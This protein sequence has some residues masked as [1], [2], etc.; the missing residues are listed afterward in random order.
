MSPS[1]TMPFTSTDAPDVSNDGSAI[2]V[3]NVQSIYEER[4]GRQSFGYNN[5]SG[6]PK[7]FSHH[8]HLVPDEGQLVEAE[9]EEEEEEEDNRDQDYN[10]GRECVD[11]FVESLGAVLAETA[12]SR[13]RQT[14][15][16]CRRL[17]IENDDLRRALSDLE[18]RLETMERDV[19][20][21]LDVRS[22]RGVASGQEQDE[23]EEG[24]LLVRL[25]RNQLELVTQQTDKRV[26]EMHRRIVLLEDELS[27]SELGRIDDALTADRE[28][29]DLASSYEEKLTNAC[30]LMAELQLDLDVTRESKADVL[31]YGHKRGGGGGRTR[32]RGL[33]RGRSAVRNGKLNRR[34]R[35]H[36]HH[37]Q[38]QM[39]GK[40]ELDVGPS[41]ARMIEEGV[42]KV[43]YYEG[44]AGDGDAIVVDSDGNADEYV[45]EFL[46]D[47]ADIVDDDDN[48][49]N[50]NN[51]NNAEEEEE[52]EEKT[53]EK[54]TIHELRDRLAA[55]D[56]TDQRPR[57]ELTKQARIVP[58]SQQQQQQRVAAD[59]EAQ[60]R[61]GLNVAHPGGTNASKSPLHNNYHEL[62]HTS[63]RTM[64][65][66]KA[67]DRQMD[68]LSPRA[69]TAT[70]TFG[71]YCDM[72]P[73][74]KAE[75]KRL[76]RAAR[77][78]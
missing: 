48:D 52:E 71:G 43:T 55:T 58:Q 44:G 68:D 9:A 28:M 47:S 70:P 42:A 73:Q 26:R 35:Q 37:Q 1:L 46:K 23:D 57:A 16:E 24:G 31:S 27:L 50:N 20:S 66:L 74:A 72:S 25:L 39:S 8:H 3:D 62:P 32:R 7:A 22:K 2:D 75:P 67:L 65:D 61:S 34:V 10:G 76:G 33:G 63:H 6:E 17:R 36:R 53:E 21:A 29:R 59:S 13:S 77:T 5:D 78:A 11:R 60:A 69:S 30:G 18:V 45:T 40:D 51:N 15:E 56:E 14:S 12:T 19:A 38:Q 54:M 49:N 4:E 41:V 64:T